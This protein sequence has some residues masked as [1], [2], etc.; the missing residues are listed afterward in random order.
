MSLLHLIWV[1][2]VG[3][4]T[5]LA[6]VSDNIL[7]RLQDRWRITVVAL[8]QPPGYAGPLHTMPGSF[9][10]D[11]LGKIVTRRLCLADPPDVLCLYYDPGPVLEFLSTWSLDVPTMAYMPV[12]SQNVMDADGLN[13]LA[14]GIFLTDFG[15][16]EAR[17]GGYTGPASV[18]GHGVDLGIYQPQDQ[19]A[20]RAELGLPQDVFLFSNVN[21]NQ[22][23]KRWDLTLYSFR[24]F[25]RMTR[26]TD[27]FLY[28]HCD[29]HSREGWHL[30]QLAAY[31]GIA[32]RVLF[33]APHL[34]GPAGFQEA[35][36]PLVYSVADVQLSTTQG[37]G[38]GLPPLEGMACGVP[39][40]IP[41]FAALAEWPGD[42]AYRV[43]VSQP[44]VMSSCTNLVEWVVDYRA[45]AEAMCTLYDSPASRQGYRARGLALVQQPQFRWDG[46]A[47]QFH[48]ILS[49]VAQHACLSAL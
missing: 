35:L 18:I 22:P 44:I 38:F 5:G 48:S 31:W 36:M 14:H 46:L 10:N 4:H 41:D 34:C 1:G 17:K 2:H 25:L 15:R 47:D 8:S 33:P 27:V 21:R 16:E 3:G 37:E 13:R 11:L 7:E 29:P 6:R 24:T 26:A 30:P 43:P 28:C 40:L 23:R 9:L 12:D 32:E 19:A 49:E 45:M 42:A 20:A 39:Q